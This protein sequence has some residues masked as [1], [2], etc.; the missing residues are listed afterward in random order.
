MSVHDLDLVGAGRLS[1]ADVREILDEHAIVVSEI[2]GFGEWLAPGRAE[3]DAARRAEERLYELADLV[4]ARATNVGVFTEELPP[5]ELIADRFGAICD[6]AGEHGL[7]VGIEP[8]VLGPLQTVALAAEVANAAARPNGGVLV[9]SYHFFRAGETVD[10]LAALE[11]AQVMMIH[12]ADA[13]AQPEGALWDDCLSRRS[14]PGQGE[15]P[16]MEFL[17]A[18]D[19][20]GVEAPIGIEIFSTELW[21]LPID[22]LLRRVATGTGELLAA[23]RDAER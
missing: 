6:R 19:R 16:V 3:Q 13:A 14:I 22:E 21:P 8:V 20:L 7:T 2:E 10:A 23:A 9:D 4:G 11:P 15:F 17:L 1:A 12:L 5:I 18:L